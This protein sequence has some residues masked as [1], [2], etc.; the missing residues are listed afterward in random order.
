MR[1]SRVPRAVAGRLPA[2]SQT[3]RAQ[4]EVRTDPISAGLTSLVTLS[5]V[6]K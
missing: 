6:N 5:E 1:N 2:G 3:L 4:K